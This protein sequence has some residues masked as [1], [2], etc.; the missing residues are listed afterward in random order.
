M[1]IRRIHAEGGILSFWKGLTASWWGISETVIHFVIYEFLKKCLA[2]HQNKKKDS[3]KTVL[4]FV[5]FMACGATSKTCATCVAYPHGKS[6][7]I[8]LF[9]KTI[10]S[11]LSI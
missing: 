7:S 10:R 5:G 4:D 3:E 9:K 2:D 11:L 6:F 1:V 8:Y